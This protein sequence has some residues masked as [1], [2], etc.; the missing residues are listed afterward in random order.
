MLWRGSNKRFSP[1]PVGGTQSQWC[2]AVQEFLVGMADAKT[3]ESHIALT[4]GPPCYAST[5]PLFLCLRG[6][7]A[8]Q[9]SAVRAASCI[10]PCGGVEVWWVGWAHGLR[11][12][13]PCHA[14]MRCGVCQALAPP[15]QPTTC[16]LPGVS[17]SGWHGQSAPRDPRGAP[18]LIESRLTWSLRG[19]PRAPAVQLCP[20]V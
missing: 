3:S 10:A 18:P 7:I 14:V 1:V 8:W 17:P 9:L 19:G 15:I 13:R 16:T 11:G 2:V 20:L 4:P 6:V 5:P 12:P